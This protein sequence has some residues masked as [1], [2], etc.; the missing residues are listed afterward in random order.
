MGVCVCVCVLEGV[1]DTLFLGGCQGA[2][3]SDNPLSHGRTAGLLSGI[4]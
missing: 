3:E 4:S 2:T 1:G